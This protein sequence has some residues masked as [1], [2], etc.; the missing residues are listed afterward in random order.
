MVNT[1]QL[2]SVISSENKC[3][4]VKS[5]C[6]WITEMYIVWIDTHKVRTLYQ[7]TD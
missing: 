4:N 1:N 5:T 2:Y 7:T 3:M 6:S